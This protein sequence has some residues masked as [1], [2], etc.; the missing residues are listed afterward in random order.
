MFSQGIFSTVAMVGAIITLFVG[1]AA[2]T[3]ARRLNKEKH[4]QHHE[5]HSG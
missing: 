3:N 1:I 5:A 2:I 4:Q